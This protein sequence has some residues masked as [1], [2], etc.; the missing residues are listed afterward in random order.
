[1]GEIIPIT[2]GGRYWR[3]IDVRILKRKDKCETWR[4]G[5]YETYWESV[6]GTRGYMRMYYISWGDVNMMYSGSGGRGGGG[7]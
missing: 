4:T 5:I 7:G 3:K 2:G 1:M 6:G